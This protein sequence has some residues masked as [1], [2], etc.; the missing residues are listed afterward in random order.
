VPIGD[1]PA[2]RCRLTRQRRRAVGLAVH[3]DARSEHAQ[4]RDEIDARQGVVATRA[5]EREERGQNERNGARPETVRCK[6]DH[7]SPRTPRFGKMGMPVTVSF[8][9]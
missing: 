9:R 1:E 6:A 4:I 8:W 3:L 2:H 7:S 5:R